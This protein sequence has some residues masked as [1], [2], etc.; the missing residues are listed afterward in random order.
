M[1]AFKSIWSAIKVL[2]L[3]RK[4][5][6]AALSGVVWAIGRVG[7][8]VTQ[9]DLLPVVGPLWAYIFGV[10]IEDAGKAKAQI[11]ANAAPKVLL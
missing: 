8:K 4:F 10:A 1:T 9:E 7:L 5:Q 2:A 11:Q 3:S 6:V